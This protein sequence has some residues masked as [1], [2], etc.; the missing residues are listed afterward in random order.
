MNYRKGG[1][2][3]DREY[4]IGT[5]SRSCQ[6]CGH[7]FGVGDEYFSA[8]VETD[9]EDRLARQDFCPACWQA[10]AGAFFSFWKTRI[11]EPEAPDRRGPALVDLG[12][13]MQLFEH[14][15]ESPDE[16][17]QRF[18][19]VLALVLMRKRRLRL[20]DSRRLRGG[21]GEVLTLREPG[22]DRQH[23]VEAPGITD[24]EIRS[25]A[26]RLREILDMPDHWDRV[27]VADEAATLAVAEPVDG[28]EPQAATASA[29][30]DEDDDDYEDD[31]DDDLD[32]DLDDDEDEDEDDDEDDEEDE[33]FGDDEGDGD[34]DA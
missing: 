25:V 22:T 7:E 10:G 23:V 24:D 31:E 6:A 3:L 30:S 17:A 1:M 32:D 33:D 12:R 29:R 13:L 5:S 15:A 28:R 16:Q 26:D 14:L 11:P 19:Y 21:R 20:A 27:S 8:V 18:R 34:P 4:K 2:V 9:E